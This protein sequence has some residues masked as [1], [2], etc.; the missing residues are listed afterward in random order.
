MTL[1][2][3]TLSTLLDKPCVKQHV[4]EPR[5]DNS[6]MLRREFNSDKHTK[7]KRRPN[8]A[9]TSRCTDNADTVTLA[10]MPTVLTN[11]K[12]KLIFQATS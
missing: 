4:V 8:S 5:R 7:P 1:R 9:E 12:R 3:L 2:T 10:H 11:S 6:T